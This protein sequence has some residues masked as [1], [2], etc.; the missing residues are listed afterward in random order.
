MNRLLTY[1]GV[2]LFV[3]GLALAITYALLP[4]SNTMVAQG[5]VAP[6]SFGSIYG[7]LAFQATGP[8][9]TSP[10]FTVSYD[11]GDSHGNV[12]LQACPASEQG[13]I[14]NQGNGPLLLNLSG[15]QA[16]GT[17][18]LSAGTWYVLSSNEPVIATVN[19]V[20]SLEVSALEYS[21]VG[22]AVGG[23]ALIG[24]GLF[25]R[26]PMN[27]PTPRLAQLKRTLYFFLQSRL[28]VVGLIIIAIFITVAILA[29]VLAPVSPANE[30]ANGTTFSLVP[31]C[32]YTPIQNP[33]AP[34]GWTWNVPP[35]QGYQQCVYS[36]PNPAPPG[37]CIPINGT[38]I[39]AIAPTWS[40]PFNMGAFPLGSLATTSTNQN[41]VINIWT[42]EIRATPWD[43]I[44]SG[45]VV[46]SG[47][48][49][50]LL[51]GAVSGYRGGYFDEVIMRITDIF[52]SIP[53]LLLVLVILTVV[54]TIISTVVVLRIA[55]VIGA[56]VVTWWPTYT[57][58]VRSQVL[59][60]R[61]QKYVEAARAS[62]AGTGR[63]LRKHVIPNALYPIFVQMSLDVG[64]VP[65][66]LASIFYLG[67]APYIFPSV[68]GLFPEWGI[69]TADSV[70]PSNFFTNFLV[71][72][73][74]I[75]WWQILIPG[76]VI[77]FFALSVNFLADGLR[78]A[79]DPR[80]RR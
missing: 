63:I 78:D 42:G 39:G 73:V 45:S 40:F 32:T 6:T 67:F 60:T 8:A 2:V 7:G 70:N 79:L 48:L 57:R 76:L 20:P 21:A 28:A 51:L 29:P 25:L 35:C 80:L 37:N 1:L 17:V 59:V 41:T 10:S 11:L 68:G 53:G 36:P 16:S 65:L 31:D 58:L 44:I 69:L 62:G 33:A 74:E 50:G 15:P 13:Q 23:L 52:L 47:A 9:G 56:L 24:V 64:T 3:V 61:E 71:S 55:V 77:F 5:P 66:L 72:N 12:W 14:C 27:R 46:G 38:E 75:P 19:V 49:I 18:T 43:L 22:A 54:S 4:E 26:D 34:G 30:S